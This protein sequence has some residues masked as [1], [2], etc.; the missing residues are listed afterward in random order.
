MSDEPIEAVRAERDR[1]ARALADCSTQLETTSAEFEQFT[2]ILSHDLRAPLRAL[3]GFS[4]ILIEDYGGKFDADGNRCLET[5]VSGARKA[6][7]LVQDLHELSRLNRQP[8]HP[9]LVNVS[10]LV[11]RQ[12]EKLRAGGAKAEFQIDDPPAAWADP[13]LLEMVFEQLLLNAVKFS[14]RQPQPSVV[15]GGRTEGERTVYFVRDNGVGFDPKY[16]G[17]LFGVFQRLHPEKDFEG[18]GI[19]LAMVQR[20][21]HRHGGK[22]WAEGKPGGGAAFCFSLPI[23]PL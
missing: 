8:F 23:R 11:S 22:V 2:H 1:L 3:E 4:K 17:R 18:R 15:I 14:R 16:A 13:A 9:D 5:L 20:L 12:A 21:V 10:L 6:S 19:G 7:A